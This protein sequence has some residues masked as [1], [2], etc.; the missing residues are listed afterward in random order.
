MNQE[1]DWIEAAANGDEAA[2]TALVESYQERVYNLTYRMLGTAEDAE[3]AAIE[4]FF[5]VYRK[6]DHY[7]RS[8][9]FS[10][11]ILS[12]ATHY[13][14]DQLRTRR[15]KWL[16]LD[17]EKISPAVFASKQPSPE[18]YVLQNEREAEVRALLDTLS[19]EHKA[20]IVLRYWY[21]MS[22]E[23]IAESTGDSLSAVKSRLFRAR[24]MLA[25]KMP[26][27]EQMAMAMA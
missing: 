21:N 3:D 9:K 13:C 11:W 2:F 26:A 6:L 16:S 18:S 1:Q 4:V 17:D 7:D 10:T 19:S 20:V 12:I 24:R 23:E 15:L 27:A 25:T 8:R 5:R 14:I 22:Y